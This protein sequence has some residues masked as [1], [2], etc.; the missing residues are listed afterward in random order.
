MFLK[1][2]CWITWKDTWKLNFCGCHLVLKWTRLSL[3]EL[4]IGS[5]KGILLFNFTVI[6]CPAT[7]PGNLKFITDSLPLFGL[8][9]TYLIA[10][11]E[12]T[13]MGGNAVP[14]EM[15]EFIWSISS[16]PWKY[17]EIKFTISDLA[18]FF[19]FFCFLFFSQLK[20]A[21]RVCLRLVY[22]CNCRVELKAVQKPVP[23]CTYM[24]YLRPL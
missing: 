2:L 17:F 11:S 13:M 21:V 10:T 20:K 12:V 19:C 24:A 7:G 16:T 15:N 6:V 23:G 18:C 3:T 5:E 22:S 4:W 1:G 14:H 9:Q 8:N